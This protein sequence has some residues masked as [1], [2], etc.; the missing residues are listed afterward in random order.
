MIDPPLIGV[1]S[2]S[3]FSEKD[4]KVTSIE[5]SLALA[6]HS[7]LSTCDKLEKEEDINPHHFS[8]E[9]EELIHALKAS[10]QGLKLLQQENKQLQLQ[11]QQS[12]QDFSDY[13]LFS[14]E[15]LKQKQLQL[16]AAQQQLDLQKNEMDKRQEQICQLDTKVRDLSYEIKTLLHLHEV[17]PDPLLPSKLS[18]NNISLWDAEEELNQKLIG[19][20]STEEY[21]ALTDCIGIIHSPIEAGRLL[22]KCIDIAQKLS[23]T[24]YYGSE[25]SRYRDFPSSY[26]AIDQRRLYDSLKSETRA[27]LVVYSQKEQK[28]LF[29]NNTTN[30]LLGWSPEKF[31][32]DFS[33]IMQEGMQDWK[34]ALQKISAQHEIQIRVLAKTRQGTEIVLNCHLGLIPSGLFRNYVIALFY[35]TS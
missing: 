14:E 26:F 35:P 32:F 18:K 33:S 6:S 3:F 5:S 4:N 13:K 28:L 19:P 20:N 21:Q 25:S 2:P 31:L 29:A 9:K 23:G 17:D 24:N 10:E 34:N 8:E 12:I 7:Q 30:G 22:K 1:Q 15:Q 11:T 27:L 16:H